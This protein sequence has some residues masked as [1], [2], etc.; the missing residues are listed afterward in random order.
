MSR[1]DVVFVLAVMVGLTLIV[2]CTMLLGV[3]SA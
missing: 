3:G 1:F 2:W